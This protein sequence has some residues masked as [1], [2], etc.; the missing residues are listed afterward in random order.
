METLKR[1]L[2]LKR[3]EIKLQ[4]EIDNNFGYSPNNI[5]FDDLFEKRNELSLIVSK[6][7]LK[8]WNL[9]QEYVQ[10][11]NLKVIKSLPT[12]L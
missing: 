9:Y 8:W 7:D 6:T 5:W 1:R 2:Q 4:E 12:F 3:F 10:S 11:D